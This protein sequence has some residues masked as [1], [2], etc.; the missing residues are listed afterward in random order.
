M[1]AMVMVLIGVGTLPGGSSVVAEGPLRLRSPGTSGGLP[2]LL[3]E[4]AVERGPA[5]ANM[6][7]DL[8]MARAAADASP[9]P[10]GLDWHLQIGGRLAGREHFR[11][12]VLLS[13][14]HNVCPCN[15]VQ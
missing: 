1:L 4:P 10:Q 15:S 12:H 11:H 5:V 13:A 6:P 7:A 8:G 3:F 9:P 14:T 2:L